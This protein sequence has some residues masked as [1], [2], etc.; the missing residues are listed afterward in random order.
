[1]RLGSGNESFHLPVYTAPRLHTRIYLPATMGIC[2]SVQEHREEG[3]LPTLKG[4]PIRK[5]DLQSI[6]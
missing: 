2:Y 5:V 6:F 3:H 4:Y 1:M